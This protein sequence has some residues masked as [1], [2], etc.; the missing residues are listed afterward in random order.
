MPTTGSG[1][2]YTVTTVNLGAPH[3]TMHYAVADFAASHA[4]IPTVL[5]AHGSGGASNQ[6]A[7]L[8]A[9]SGLR[10]WL[11][12]NGWAFVEGEG[13]AGG[14]QNW[15]NPASRAAYPAYLARARQALDLG[16]VVLLGR[17][18]GG[19]V[20]AW[21]YAHDTAGQYAGWINNSG[22]STLFEG[23]SDG[24]GSAL[25][26]STGRAF[27][28]TCWNGW[29]ASTYAEWAA[30]AT[31]ADAAP[32]AWPATVWAGKKIL[33][34]YGDADPTAPWVPRGGGPLR[35][36][37]AGAPAV[38]LTSVRIGGDHSAT[39]GS[40]LD[41]EAMSSFLA[42]IGGGS[43]PTPEP[44]AYLRVVRAWTVLDGKRYAFSPK[45]VTVIA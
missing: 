38:D 6:F 11:I 20:T 27:G 30:L 39:N 14:A 17:S 18:M 15:G 42:E 21:L 24:G 37:W 16:P 13:G 25:T 8:G 43:T 45:P 32:E 35:A 31:S 5:Y 44:P 9:W 41:V 10:D 36:I 23:V 28:A 29:G 2:A 12:D 1:T 4:D 33:N 7:T 26:K 19:L 34:C 3:G 40:Y 22:V